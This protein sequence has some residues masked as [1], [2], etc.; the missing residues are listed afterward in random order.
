METFAPD[1]FFALAGLCM[2]VHLALGWIVRFAMR[3]DEHVLGEV[4]GFSTFGKLLTRRPH[5]MRAR[6]FLP[7]VPIQSVESY[8]L[9]TRAI[10]WIARLSGTGFI[11]SL[12]G[13]VGSVIYTAVRGA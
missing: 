12:L 11:V 13:L 1:L 4:F 8:S 2:G 6:L 5:L 7:W 3:S 9:P 10:V